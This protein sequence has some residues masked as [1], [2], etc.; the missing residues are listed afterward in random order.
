[1]SIVYAERV[2]LLTPKLL[3]MIFPAIYC[4]H[5]VRYGADHIFEARFNRYAL[6]R[7]YNM[8]IIEYIRYTMAEYIFIYETYDV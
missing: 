7:I 5:A 4:L 6:S 1:M 2:L 3:T 8:V